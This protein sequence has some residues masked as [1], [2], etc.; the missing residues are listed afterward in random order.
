MVGLTIE[1]VGME[2]GALPEF[3]LKVRLIVKRSKYVR[4]LFL[5]P[6]LLDSSDSGLEEE[7]FTP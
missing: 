7:C 6:K 4:V 3:S 2:K 1:S 5:L